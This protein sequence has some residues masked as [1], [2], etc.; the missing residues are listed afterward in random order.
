M[1]YFTIISFLIVLSFI[2]GCAYER[3]RVIL[4]LKRLH[5][6][7]HTIANKDEEYK[8]TY[9]TALGEVNYNL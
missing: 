4:I 7:V 5:E 1:L 2:V 9:L 6:D 3:V 8:K